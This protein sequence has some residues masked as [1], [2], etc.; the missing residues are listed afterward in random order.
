MEFEHRPLDWFRPYAR[1]P[2][3]NDHAIGRLEAMCPDG[4]D[5]TGE[6]LGVCSLIEGF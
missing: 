5:H 6:E 1:H 2:R 3:V 4:R